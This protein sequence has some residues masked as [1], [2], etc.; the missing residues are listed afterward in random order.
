MHFRRKTPELFST[1]FCFLLVAVTSS[2]TTRYVDINSATP[3]PPYTSWGT[4]AR[5]IQDA[6]D[7]A[8]AGDL[9]LVTNG[10]YSTGGKAKSGDLTNR[11]ALDK[12]LTVQSVNGPQVTAIDGTSSE[13][14]PAASRC[15]WLTNGAVLGGF[16]LRNGATRS[17]GGPSD[18]LH[19]GGIYGNSL[20]ARATNCIITENSSYSGGGGASQV[21]LVN[22]ILN[23]N[24]CSSQV[25]GTGGGA[26]SCNLTNCI[27]TRNTAVSGGGTYNSKLRNC[28]VTQN[29]GGGANS[30]TL[31]NCTVTG[32][33]GSIGGGVANATLVN[34]IVFGNQGLSGSNYSTC[35]FSYSC[36]S[37]LPS[38]TGNI[39]LDPQ[40][41]GDGVHLSASSPCRAAGTTLAGAS[42]D[43]DSQS[44]ANPPSMGCD[45]WVAAPFFAQQP[46]PRFEGFPP[47]LKIGPVMVAGQEPFGFWW[48]KDSSLLQDGPDYGSTHS[49]NLIVTN[50]SLADMGNYQVVASNAFGVVTS[51]VAKVLVHCVDVAG[52][53]P[54]P[55]YSDWAT[56]ATNIQDAI[57]VAV[58]GDFV[59]ITNGVYATG[60]RALSTGGSS[61]VAITKPL[62]VTSVNGPSVTVIQGSIS[63]SAVRCAWV[64][65]GATLRGFTLQGGS[66]S[67]G[68]GVY[69]PSTN[70][71][72]ANCSVISNTAFG[73]GGGGCYGGLVSN[74]SIIGN[75]SSQFGGGTYGSF[76]MGSLV[77]SNSAQYGGGGTYYGTVLNST[78]LGNFSSSGSAGGSYG[79]T[80][81]NSIVYFNS[82]FIPGSQYPNYDQGSGR[83]I[84]SYTCT[85]P[86]VSGTGNISAGPQL[87]N[88][89]YLTSTSPC[90]GAGSAFYSS[91]VDIDGEAWANPPSMGCDE[92]WES[93]VTGPLAVT[94]RTGWPAVAQTKFM[95]LIGQVIGRATRMI[96]SYGDGTVL[97]NASFSIVSHAW[98]NP[99]D[100]TVVF[101]A[102]NADYPGG[103]STNVVAHVLPWVS[104]QIGAG[105]LNGTNFNLSFLPLP[106]V[107]Y[108]V[109]Q[110]TNLT[111]PVVWRTI[112]TLFPSD[113]NTL[114]VTD[115]KA[116]N[117]M[118]F[119]RIQMQ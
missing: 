78:I 55:P 48:Y 72:V 36:S 30:G 21:V 38:G 109:Q 68:G 80:I 76:V 18:Q 114:Q 17:N 103:V 1:V 73:F 11:V 88:N 87:L 96:W 28:A 58:D 92:L 100:Y 62:I 8:S 99:G 43:I 40:L 83:P 75:Q 12:A 108:F 102:F 34:S 61:R 45:E 5:V 42:T 53:A 64:S 67:L 71:Y 23:G 54:V 24:A 118:R 107:F 91:G 110:T 33:A 14:G 119:Y 51:A 50:F 66:E 25:N 15:A 10:I 115:T 22:C 47:T 7:A 113:T 82:V 90:R 116:T 59:L 97:T 39:A 77:S 79:G 2:A 52:S 35:T 60:A 32:N 89:I 46:I 84:F 70:E 74:C 13:P 26:E 19:G 85:T 101:T 57:D 4:A 6:I 16:T 81:A 104:P 20:A 86:A 37:P 111:P 69:A 27:V 3:T 117:N 94:L 98:M 106:G 41:L 65:D 63:P 9:V 95:S 29:A 105:G 31:V 112:S 44:W 56:A 93:N 49:T